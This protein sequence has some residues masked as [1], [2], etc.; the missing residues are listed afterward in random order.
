M[1]HTSQQPAELL[2]GYTCHEWNF[3]EPLCP[4]DLPWRLGEEH[5]IFSYSTADH[6]SLSNVDK[7]AGY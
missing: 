3:V 4:E 6:F 1:T 2:A 7:E 5:S